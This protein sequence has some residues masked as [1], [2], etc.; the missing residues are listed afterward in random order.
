QEAAGQG[1]LF[2]MFAEDTVAEEAPVPVVEIPEWDDFDRL[3]QE[4]DVLGL[5]L[6]GHPIQGVMDEIR[7][8]TDMRFGELT[9]QL[10][11]MAPKANGRPQERHVVVAGL[12]I[13]VRPRITQQG[14]KEAF[15]LLDDG[16]GRIEARLF[17]E[18]YKRHA[19][20]LGKDQVLVLEGGASFDTFS[21]GVR[22]RVKSLMTLDQ[23]REAY[24]RELRLV[25][26]A[27]FGPDGVDRLANTLAP[28]RPGR[29]PVLL[30]VR[31]G[32]ARGHMVL[33]D[34]WRV[35]PSSEL[36]RRLRQLSEIERVELKHARSS[37]MA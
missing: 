31:N 2:G 33:G 27:G 15:L 22:L 24:A 26:S 5:Y 28:F 13:G 4:K 37:A 3:A 14:E 19:E 23:A 1:D 7:Q 8:F 32:Q 10:E 21:G 11:D 18:D 29:C 16:T 34:A 20:Q 9:G 17:P 35:T 12:M 25:L 36:L 30:D 6:T